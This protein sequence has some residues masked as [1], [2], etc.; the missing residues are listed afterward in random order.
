MSA[1][2]VTD[3]HAWWKPAG[4]EICYIAGSGLDLM[5]VAVQPGGEALEV[6]TPHV[7]FRL[8]PDVVGLDLAPDGQRV[9]ISVP[10]SGDDSRK[11]RVI[12]N[13]TGL[14]KR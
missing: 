1:G 5:S 7:L 10:Q 11:V 6:G 12:L 2:G 13:W 3:A 4:N 8:P 14:A 9:L